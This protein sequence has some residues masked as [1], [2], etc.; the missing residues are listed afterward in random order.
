MSRVID[1]CWLIHNSPGLNSDSLDEIKLSSHFVKNFNIQFN[2]SFSKIL[3]QTESRVTGRWF[4]R[5]YL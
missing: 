3:S 5:I 2:I 1:E 4:L